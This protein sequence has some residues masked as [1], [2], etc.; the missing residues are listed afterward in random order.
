MCANITSELGKLGANQ[1][2]LQTSLNVLG[3][4]RENFLQ[5]SGRIKDADIALESAQLTRL[6]ILQRASVAVLG[7]ANL[8][9]SLAV[10]LLS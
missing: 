6:E 2:R 5:A 4:Q 8:Q 9:P 7:Q 1:S 3:V 10:Q